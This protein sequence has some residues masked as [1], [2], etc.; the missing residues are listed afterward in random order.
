MKIALPILTLA[1]SGCAMSP[2]Q[3]KA[4]GP[5]DKAACFHARC[6]SLTC[7]GKWSTTTTGAAASDGKVPTVNERCEIGGKP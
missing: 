4:L 3:I 5:G 7:G 1:L 6:E 2:E